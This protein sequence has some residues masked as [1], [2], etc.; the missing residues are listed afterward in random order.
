MRE[1]TT[2]TVPA[3]EQDSTFSVVPRQRKPYVKPSQ[4][5]IDERVNYIIDCL[6][7]GMK[8]GDII[9]D[10]KVRYDVTARTIATYLSRARE[11]MVDETKESRAAHRIKR[12]EWYHAVVD[13]PDVQW[14]DRIRAAERIDKLLGLEIHESSSKRVVEVSGPNGQPI[15]SV[16]VVAGVD[17]SE[18]LA[19]FADS[20][21]A[22]AISNAKEA[23]LIQAQPPSEQEK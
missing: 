14:R 23:Q 21:R 8:D 22:A 19:K 4:T 18:Q 20:I 16:S 6:C 3:S 2:T 15:Q 13:N 5:D 10:C 11:K 7:D 12:L 17:L 1:Q 9:R